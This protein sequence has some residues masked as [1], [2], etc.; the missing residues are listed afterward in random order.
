MQY[1]GGAGRHAHVRERAD[2]QDHP[3]R[4]DHRKALDLLGPYVRGSGED[5]VEAFPADRDLRHPQP[6]VEDVHGLPE[7]AH[8]DAAVREAGAVRRDAYLRGAELQPRPR[9][10]LGPAGARQRLEELPH[11]PAG[12]FQD[13]LEVGTLDVEVDPLAA[14]DG[15]PEQ[16]RLGHE[17]VGAGLPEHGAGKHRDE[18]AGAL[19]LG[20]GRADEGARRRWRRR[21]SGRSRAAAAG[22]LPP[23]GR[24]G[25]RRHGRNSAAPRRLGG[26]ARRRTHGGSWGG[27]SRPRRGP[28]VGGGGRILA[29]PPGA[30]GPRLPR[31]RLPGPELPDRAL[32][33]PRDLGGG[34]EVVA[35]WGQDDPEDEV[36]V[37]LRQVLELREKTP[38]GRSSSPR[39]PRRR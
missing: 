22:A 28:P 7:L 33:V 16:G 18:L 38:G 37:A 8:A 14:A 17:S 25:G 3:R 29:R 20:A 15:A 32:D 26:R 11:G 31:T 36:P 6:V 12:D 30:A 19:R 9:P 21:R 23:R 10:D 2:R 35:G 4:R 34:L 27:R 39:T 5:E 24:I 13:R 1:L